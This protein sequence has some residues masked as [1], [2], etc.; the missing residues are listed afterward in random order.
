MDF[1]GKQE[2]QRKVST[3]ERREERKKERERKNRKGKRKNEGR[4]R[5]DRLTR[6]QKPF[7]YVM[8]SLEQHRKKKNSPNG[9]AKKEKKPD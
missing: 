5:D 1:C 2:R 4:I 7:D 6:H 3:G 8:E 9:K